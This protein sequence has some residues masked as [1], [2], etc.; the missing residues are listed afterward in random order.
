MMMNNHHYLKGDQATMNDNVFLTGIMS[1]S[2]GF[3]EVDIYLELDDT[4]NNAGGSS[5]MGDTSDAPQ[6]IPTPT[7]RRRQHT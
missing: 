1:F 4:F 6:P 5:S 3:H 7:L 2:S